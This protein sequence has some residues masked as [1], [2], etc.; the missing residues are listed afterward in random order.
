MDMPI[1]PIAERDTDHRCP[2]CG[3]ETELVSFALTHRDG[4]KHQVEVTSKRR[5]CAA[6]DC[7]GHNGLDEPAD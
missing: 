3:G 5:R 6:L 7:Q 1:E 2:I 4:Q